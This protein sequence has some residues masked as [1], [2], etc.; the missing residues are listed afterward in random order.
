MK[1]IFFSLVV[2]ITLICLGTMSADAQIKK[3][4]YNTKGNPVAM[5]RL[6]MEI[7]LQNQNQQAINEIRAGQPFNIRAI[8]TNSGNAEGRITRLEL[9]DNGQRINPPL[10]TIEVQNNGRMPYKATSCEVIIRNIVIQQQGQHTIT[11][12]L[13]DG[14]NNIIPGNNSVPLQVIAPQVQQPAGRASIDIIDPIEINP[15][16]L[17]PEDIFIIN[18]NARN[19]GAAHG[20]IERVEVTDN[21]NVI[22]NLIL[23]VNAQHGR[24]VIPN[25]NQSYPISV[26]CQPLQTGRH[27]I[28]VRFFYSSAAEHQEH[29]FDSPY[30]DPV[31]LEISEPQ[32]QPSFDN[33]QPRIIAIAP[34]RP[35]IN[36]PFGVTT[37][38]TNSG[39][40]P[41]TITMSRIFEGD[42]TIGTNNERFE[43]NP[44]ITI[45]KNIA[46][47]GIRHPGEHTIVTKFFDINN[48]P[49]SSEPFT[50]NVIAANFN[51]SSIS[52]ASHSIIANQL[53]TVTA[54]ITNSGN[55]LGTINTSTILLPNGNPISTG[56]NVSQRINIKPGETVTK[57]IQ[58]FIMQQGEYDIILELTDSNNNVYRS[59]PFHIVVEPAP[60]RLPNLSIARVFA[61][62]ENREIDIVPSNTPFTISIVVSNREGQ[63]DGILSNIEIRDNNAI[64][65]LPAPNRNVTVTRGQ[66]LTIPIRIP[67]GI[68][69]P[70]EHRIMVTL[71]DNNNNSIPGNNLVALQ[72]QEAPRPQPQLA[73]SNIAITN[74]QN[75]PINSIIAGQ[76]FN[77]AV[78]VNNSGNAEGVIQRAEAIDNNNLM[79]PQPQVNLSNNGRIPAGERNYRIEFLN[80][81]IQNPGPHQINVRLTDSSGNRY[82]VNPIILQVQ[83]EPRPEVIINSVTATANINLRDRPQPVTVNIEAR[84]NNAPS[85]INVEILDPDNNRLELV[86]NILLNVN[87][88]TRV[89]PITTSQNAPRSTRQVRIIIT[90]EDNTVIF[91]QQID[92]ANQ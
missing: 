58:C 43:I 90:R 83:E 28:R 38:I 31:I 2:S 45:N 73:I 75:Q 11:L 6:S 54:N 60:Q 70:G 37:R 42:N 86:R 62:I 3:Q 35:S 92:I 9:S 24:I 68:Q 23:N 67:N 82:D 39:N 57:D 21:F 29:I 7:S 40:G 32:A 22:P 4:P 33:P 72:V 63:A 88:D 13:R 50:F 65:P 8:V 84:S 47:Q 12:Q 78:T 74:L 64:I 15:N 17:R 41:A 26:Q 49:I 10:N 55:G 51:E 56:R 85:T 36:E 1:K 25:D 19:F 66:E 91:D 61:T 53:F 16:P 44:N 79:N 69:Q 27:T 30:S 77:I 59:T 18:I 87:V 20:I 81:I 34:S 52:R 5:P 48:T 89:P 14:N 46:C 80:A 71:I 76:P